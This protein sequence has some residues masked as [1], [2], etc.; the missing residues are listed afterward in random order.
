MNARTLFR[1]VGLTVALSTLAAP[2]FTLTADAAP[3][4]TAQS[5]V[6]FPDSPSGRCAKAFVDMINA[7]DEDTIRSFEESYRADARRKEVTIQQRIPRILNV[8]KEFAPL[9]VQKVTDD[10]S[11]A[12]F[13]RTGMGDDIAMVFEM[14]PTQPAKMDG[15]NIMP[16]KEYEPPRAIDAAAR[17]ETVE[18]VCGV[19]EKQYVYPDVAK[20]MTEHVRTR[21]KSGAYNDYATENTLAAILS[22]DL[23][24]ISHDKHLDVRSVPNPPP[25][26]TEEDTASATDEE[27]VMP[28]EA[29]AEWAKSNFAFREAKVLDGNIGYL[30]FNLFIMSERSK[31]TA[32]AAMNFLANTDALI[33]DLRENG[34]GD[35]RMIA[36]LTTYLFDSKTHLNDMVD[37]NGKTVEEFW[38]LESVPGQR[39]RPGVPVYVLTSGMTFS[40]AEEF[41]YNLK[42]LKR[43]TIIGETTGGGAHPVKNVTARGHVA[44]RVPFMRANNPI[45]KTNWEGTGVAPDIEVPAAEALDRA[46]AEARDTLRRKK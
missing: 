26:E 8:R 22:A 9:T 11:L 24:S 33:V 39:L 3:A 12:V 35:P 25:P 18:A 10:G 28:P 44:V 16:A 13:A 41:S 40:G 17:A 31:Q 36:F 1:L 46:L 42:N 4:P 6:T 19:L 34:G 32:A 14:S 7:R 38:T 29:E 5:P 2:T 15:V 20:K 43:A 21:L 23:R 30:K 27:P 45:S 37:R